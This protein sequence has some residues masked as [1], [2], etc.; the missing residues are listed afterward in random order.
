[1]QTRKLLWMEYKAAHPG[2]LWTPASSKQ[3]LS[4]WQ[5]VYSG[6]RSIDTPECI[7]LARQVQ[8]DYAGDTVRRSR[9]DNG[10][11]REARIFVACLPCSGLIYAEASWTQATED[12]L[13]AHVRLFMAFLGE[14][15][16][17]VIPDNLKGSALPHRQLLR[18][19]DQCQL[20]RTDQALRCGCGANTV[21]QAAQDKPGVENGVL[22]ACRWI[23]APL[24][25]RQFFL[26][27]RTEPGDRA[28]CWRSSTTSR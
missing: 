14:I 23:L 24:R 28:C 26:V 3:R 12:W 6:A 8:V 5:K 13:G 17:K 20:C 18:S 1:M 16:A 7:M 22:Q 10:T 2:G 9:M 4:D 11:A 21:A 25:H 27:G 19:G 15:A